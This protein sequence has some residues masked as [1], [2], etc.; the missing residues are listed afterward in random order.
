[1]F[2]KI[3]YATVNLTIAIAKHYFSP[4]ISTLCNLHLWYNLLG[5]VYSRLQYLD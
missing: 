3:L 1:M 4:P 5:L 2:H